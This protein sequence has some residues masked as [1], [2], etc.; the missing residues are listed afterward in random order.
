MYTVKIN[1]IMNENEFMVAHMDN[2]SLTK[3]GGDSIIGVVVNHH[4]FSVCSR[5]TSILV[6]L[7]RNCTDYQDV[8]TSKK[9]TQ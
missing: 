2:K 3:I 9:R 6:H 1:Y 8:L 7:D 4:S 5:R